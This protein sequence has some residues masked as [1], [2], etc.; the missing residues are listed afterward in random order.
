MKHPQFTQLAL[1][2]LLIPLLATSAA[3]VIILT[4]VQGLVFNDP[5]QLPPDRLGLVLGCPPTVVSGK[6]NTYFEQRM[7]AAATLIR[8]RV[9]K[10]LILSGATDGGSY[11]EP[12]AM[13][14]ALIKRGLS[15]NDFYADDGGNR[16]YDSLL[17]AHQ[18][19][20]GQPIII[21]TQR[22]HAKRALY[23]AKHL[24]IDAIA[25]DAQTPDFNDTLILTLRESLARVRAILDIYW[26]EVRFVD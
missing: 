9:I 15:A 17:N 4:S 11:N 18:Q 20:P 5:L 22:S 26:P 25:F 8:A 7:D 13:K 24:G 16:T 23:L 10:R 21:I 14:R 6:P 12:L 1:T 3:N 19:H 2:I